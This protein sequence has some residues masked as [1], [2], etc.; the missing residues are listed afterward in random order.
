MIKEDRAKRKGET[1]ITENDADANV[2]KQNSRL[3]KDSPMTITTENGK[4]VITID[5][6]K[7]KKIREERVKRQ[8]EVGKKSAFE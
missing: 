5:K 2:K 4:T 8:Q 3:S 1:T 6:E 7:A